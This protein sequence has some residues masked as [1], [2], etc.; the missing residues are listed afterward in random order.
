MI[1]I[2][3]SSEK[4]VDEIKK[5]IGNINETDNNNKQFCISIEE[6]NENVCK[7][8]KKVIK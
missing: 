8:I 1:K 7:E 5:L 6:Q 2:Q 3:K 4:N